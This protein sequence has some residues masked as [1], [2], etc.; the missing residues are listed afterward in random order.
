[1]NS[2]RRGGGQNAARIMRLSNGCGESPA[3]SAAANPRGLPGQPGLG[4]T[5]A[6]NG[7]RRHNFTQACPA[8]LI[9]AYFRTKVSLILTM[10]SAILPLFTFTS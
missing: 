6:E 1:M 5:H 10:Y 4:S 3:R 2:E 7:K 8:L 9:T